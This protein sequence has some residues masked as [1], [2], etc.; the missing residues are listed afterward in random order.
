[1][2]ND[3]IFDDEMGRSIMELYES[4]DKIKLPD[5]IKK[6]NDKENIKGKI[7][8]EK[9]LR[10]IREDKNCQNK[11]IVEQRKE[12][13]NFKIIVLDTE[14]ECEEFESETPEVVEDIDLNVLLK[15][16]NKISLES[17]TKETNKTNKKKK[18]NKCEAKKEIN[19]ESDQ[20]I[21]E[22][23][24]SQRMKNLYKNAQIFE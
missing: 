18:E 23:P 4:G 10:K 2:K 1:M 11:K 7:E 19:N 21:I 15:S 5:D 24:F 3:E 17:K 9:I 20:D 8:N 13:Q 16:F 12:R 14:S 22:I 6:M